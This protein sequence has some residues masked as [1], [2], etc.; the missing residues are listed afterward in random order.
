MRR[1][2]VGQCQ[3]LKTETEFTPGEWKH[4]ARNDAQGKC[5]Q[6]M[7][8]HFGRWRCQACKNLLSNNLFSKWLTNRK[9]KSKNDGKQICDDCTENAQASPIRQLPQGWWQCSVCEKQLKRAEFSTFMS[10]HP[11]VKKHQFVR[12][13]MCEGVHADSEQKKKL[14]NLRFVQIGAGSPSMEDSSSD[15]NTLTSHTVPR[16]DSSNVA[17]DESHVQGRLTSAQE[18]AC[19]QK[20]QGGQGE[21]K[22]TR[23]MAIS[24]AH[25]KVA[26][27]VW[28][29]W[30]DTCQKKERNYGVSLTD[31]PEQLRCQGCGGRFR[32]NSSAK[33]FWLEEEDSKHPLFCSHCRIICEQSDFSS[34]QLTKGRRKKCNWCATP[35]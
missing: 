20:K 27:H 9:D 10:S 22:K 32:V 7:D 31:E 29:F 21:R 28:C 15:V 1:Q 25:N 11:S 5:R 16:T 19:K 17:Q 14:D 35:Q 26:R 24:T 33:A 3:Q 6:C 12:C 23:L 2:C 13:N 4:A 34:F 18:S 8:K 30:H